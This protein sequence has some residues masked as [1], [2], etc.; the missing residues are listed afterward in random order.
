MWC[1][2]V[3]VTEKTE[4]VPDCRC[5]FECALIVRVSVRASEYDCAFVS[6]CV[7]VCVSVRVSECGCVC[8]CAYACACVC[9]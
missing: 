5:R 3:R 4:H 8:R 7:R 1:V 6:G 9:A 2:S